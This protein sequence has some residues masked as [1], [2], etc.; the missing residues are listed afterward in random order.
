MEDQK[1]DGRIEEG[2]DE[3][4][5]PATFEDEAITELA[6]KIVIP[7]T[8]VEQSR[9]DLFPSSRRFIKHGA[10]MVHIGKQDSISEIDF[11]EKSFHL[12]R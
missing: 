2:C 7:D 11:E 9:E 5:A 8:F 12:L 6:E 4:P 10:L 3:M 1:V